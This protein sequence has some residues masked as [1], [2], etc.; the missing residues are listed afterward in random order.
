[1]TRYSILKD[2][3]ITFRELKDLID[4][5][6]FKEFYGDK[7]HII[8]DIGF[9]KIT[10]MV[11]SYK[12]VHHLG[13]RRIKFYAFVR[14][15]VYFDCKEFASAI[16][17]K[18]ELGSKCVLSHDPIDITRYQ[19][20]LVLTNEGYKKYEKAYEKY[21][22]FTWEKLKNCVHDLLLNDNFEI[23]SNEV[24]IF[25]DAIIVNSHVKNTNPRLKFCENHEILFEREDG[26]SVVFMENVPY[27]KMK[28]II[29]S[30]IMKEEEDV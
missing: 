24:E 23:L 6:T 4:S 22:E 1:M 7:H 5:N 16:I 21:C 12:E 2:N 26:L 18:E 25:S 17:D 29:K 13:S 9:S 14:N 30:L 8:E 20:F 27:K 15:N 10:D 28:E 3:A 19:R 11:F